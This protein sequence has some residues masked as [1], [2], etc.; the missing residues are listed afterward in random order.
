[1][2]APWHLWV[3]GFAALI[4]NGGGAFDYLMTQLGNEAYLSMLTEPQRAFI[5][6]RP[7]WMDAAW[8]VGVWFSVLGSL[9]ILMRA[10]QAALA[11]ALSITG[12]LVTAIWSYGIADPSGI[13]VMGN[14][15]VWFSLAITAVLI[16]LWAYSRA[17]TVRGVLR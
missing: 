12:M 17:M 13:E 14:F 16:A 2:R 1:M 5:D 15:S 4:W 3:I 8:A 6:A 11:F 9:L 7:I 10:R